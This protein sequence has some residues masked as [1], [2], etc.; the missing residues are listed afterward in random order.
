MF[1]GSGG[2]HQYVQQVFGKCGMAVFDWMSFYMIRPSSIAFF[3]IKFV[4]LVCNTFPGNYSE[5]YWVILLFSCLF[6]LL[7][8]LFSYFA[9][10]ASD[11]LQSVLTYAKIVA[12]ISAIFMSFAAL[13][14]NKG[15]IFYK[16]RTEMLHNSPNFTDAFVA[17]I[18]TFDGWNAVN[19]IA[20]KFKNP[21]KTIP[22]SILWGNMMIV[23]LYLIIAFAHFFVV[24]KFNN[25]KSIFSS[26]GSVFDHEIWFQSIGNPIICLAVLSATQA[27]ITSA[28][29]CFSC[30]VED[31]TLKQFLLKESKQG[32]FGWLLSIQAILSCAH[33]FLAA[34]LAAIAGKIGTTSDHACQMNIIPLCIFYAISII[35]IIVNH[36]KKTHKNHAY[37]AFV[38]F[39]YLFIVSIVIV[40]CGLVYSDVFSQN[41]D[42]STIG[43]CGIIFSSFLVCIIF[44]YSLNFKRIEVTP[45][46][47]Q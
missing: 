19:S 46:K 29:E 6:V 36:F 17:A 38:L 13:A 20:G 4:I 21:S 14:Y 8:T 9:P 5:R 34:G 12:L 32:T 44:Y 1:P 37:K 47:K 3:A 2:E 31:G 27:Q 22:Q 15:Q 39:P 10:K 43:R 23:I 25:F 45:S 40:L 41:A 18:L 7:I 30:G 33:I 42:K 26:I 35:P 28:V 16:N 11:K 24:T